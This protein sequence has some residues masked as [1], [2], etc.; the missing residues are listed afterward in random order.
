MAWRSSATWP[1]T[2]SGDPLAVA[3]PHVHRGGEGGEHGDVATL[4]IAVLGGRRK[5]GVNPRSPSHSRSS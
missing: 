2:R 1:R 5:A 3:R 4:Q